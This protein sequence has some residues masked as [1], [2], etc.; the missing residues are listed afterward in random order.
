MAVINED[1]TGKMGIKMTIENYSDKYYMA[2]IKVF[3]VSVLVP[4]SS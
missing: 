3:L 2:S 1:G 4:M